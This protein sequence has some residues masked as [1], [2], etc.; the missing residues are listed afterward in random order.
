LE[1]EMLIAA[2]RLEFEKAGE[3]RDEI[4]DIKASL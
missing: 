1:E 4:K 3:I 2:D